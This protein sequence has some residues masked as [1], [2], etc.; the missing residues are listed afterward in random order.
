MYKA[1]MDLCQVTKHLKLKFGIILKGDT[2]NEFPI[3]S[4]FE[5][6][7]NQYLTIKPYPF[8]TVDISNKKDRPWTPNQSF[9]ISGMSKYLFTKRLREIRLDLMN[10]KEL[11]F[12]RDGKLYVNQELAKKHAKPV[13]VGKGKT[14]LF[15]PIV[16]EDESSGDQ[17]EGVSMMINSP[18]NYSNFT[19]EE[20]EFLIDYL[21]RLDLDSLTINFLNFVLQKHGQ[22]TL[23]KNLKEV[24]KGVMYGVQK[25][26]Q[27]EKKEGKENDE[28]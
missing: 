24:Y 28:H 9:T 17:Y 26:N 6:D 5:K 1:S 27:F 19:F 4:T 3:V 8:I 11:F 16:V 13:P 10:D 21:E 23:V 14:C 22:A 15:I 7:G 12:T 2:P 25:I 20:M 18:E